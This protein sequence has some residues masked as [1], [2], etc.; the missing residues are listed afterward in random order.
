MTSGTR[1]T[2]PQFDQLIDGEPTSARPTDVSQREP[3]GLAQPAL[4][5]APVVAVVIPARNEQARIARCLA[6][7]DQALAL[8]GLVAEAVIV[9]D[10]ASTDDTARVASRSGATVLHQ[11]SRQ[12]P[13][14]AW[15]LGV[16]ST[17]ASVVILVDADCEV[18]PDSLTGL[19]SPFTE[20]DVGVTAARSVPVRATGRA[21]LARRSARFSS[22]LLHEI[23]SRLTDHDFLPMGKLMAV[24]REAWL[25]TNTRLAPCDRVVA[26]LARD[27]DWQ[28]R[29]VPESKVF[30]LA[31]GSIR[32]L[33]LDYR[34]TGVV[35]SKLPLAHD[36]FP[37][38]ALLRGGLAAL[39]VAPA[40]A[41]VWVICRS[42]L[43]AASG[44][45]R[46]ERQVADVW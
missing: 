15:Q 22:L 13:L 5:Q 39:L 8:A 10:D 30:Y 40:D 6:S 44:V 14:A 32:E 1:P 7:V 41:L 29:Y 11:L 28:V 18:A 38:G 21:R 36:A 9:V 33:W 24:R 42:F 23:K 12:G 2:E 25:V 17:R 16:R 46:R 45:S 43:M 19:L 31:A 3:V 20:P 34:R 4:R 27:A 35:S 37:R 26:K